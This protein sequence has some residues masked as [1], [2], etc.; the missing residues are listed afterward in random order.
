[1]LEGE[2][3]RIRALGS[4]DFISLPGGWGN[5][6][7]NEDGV[8]DGGES[9]VRLALED[10]DKVVAFEKGGRERE[11]ERERRREGGGR[12]EGIRDRWCADS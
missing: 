12:E 7:G 3:G 9:A 5:K 10:P 8:D 11:K 2:G 6:G 4:R 1:M